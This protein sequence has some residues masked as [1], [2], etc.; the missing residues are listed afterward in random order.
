MVG[1]KIQATKI[2]KLKIKM[3][4]TDFIFFY[5]SIYLIEQ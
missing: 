2:Q 3:N 1:Y 4:L 5:F